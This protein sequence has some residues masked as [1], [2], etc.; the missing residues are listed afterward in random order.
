MRK[1]IIASVAALALLVTACSDDEVSTFCED[2]QQLESS[3]DTLRDIDIAADGTDALKADVEA[4]TTALGDLRE[5]G[6]DEIGDEVD[7]LQQSLSSLQ[8][9]V[10]AAS[11][12]G[13][14]ASALVSGLAD[15]Q[16]SLQALLSAAED[17]VESC[18]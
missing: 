12:T 5:S 11:G 13:A 6:G 15:V 16:T 4:V 1:R 2:E 18:D 8:S 17:A 3:I 14:K 7:D 10:E 9:G